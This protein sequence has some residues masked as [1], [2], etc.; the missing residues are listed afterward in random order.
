MNLIKFICSLVL[1][2]TLASCG[3]S[4]LTEEYMADTPKIIAIKLS[5]PEVRPGN[6]VTMRLLIAGKDIDQNMTSTIFWYAEYQEEIL[7]GWSSYN[8]DFTLNIPETIIDSNEDDLILPVFARIQIGETYLT[9]EKLLRITHNPTG[10]NP[11]INEVTMK[12]ISNDS[13]MS[14]TLKNGESLTIP[15]NTENISL[16]AV[17]EELEAGANDQLIY[18]WYVSFS[19][20][21]SNKLWV[22]DDEDTI[23]ELLGEGA[24]A[25]EFRKSVIYSLRGEENDEEIQSGTYDIYLVI[26]DNASNSQSSDEDRLGMDFLYFTV[27][28]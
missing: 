14:S 26:R 20:T 24:T 12:Y 21:S 13:I 11:H 1:I 4:D 8:E 18:R 2:F 15:E 28:L 25:A 22:Y 10:K 17:T 27:K 16:T 9:A 7:G 5:D 6:E 23:E 19:K 3:E